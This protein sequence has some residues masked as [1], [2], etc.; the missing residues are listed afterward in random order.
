V[1]SHVPQEPLQQSLSWLQPTPFCAP[2]PPPHVLL[3]VPHVAP[4]QQ[5]LELA[6]PAPVAAHPHVPL[7]HVPLQQSLGCEQ[8][9]PSCKPVAP[10]HV[11]SHVL[12]SRLPQHSVDDAH[13]PP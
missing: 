3:H 11:P 9:A 13:V 5:S 7:A 10:P 2:L 4:P 6:H 12:Q 8:L 1:P